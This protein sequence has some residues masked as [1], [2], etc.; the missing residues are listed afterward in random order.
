MRKQFLLLLLLFILSVVTGC[1]NG[2]VSCS[3]TVKYST[4][5]PVPEGMIFF[6]TPQLNYTGTIT[7]GTFEVGGLKEKDG[8]PLG[9]YNIPF[10]G[11]Q[12]VEG[13]DQSIPLFDSKYNNPETSG[14]TVE[15][16][17]GTNNQFDFVVEKAN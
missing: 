14:I 15:V 12:T 3:G 7:N 6:S 13:T 11:S 1:G 17:G 2:H 8:L 10:M 4:G 16:K 5:E 9:Q